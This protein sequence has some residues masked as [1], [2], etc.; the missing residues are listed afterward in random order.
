M[1]TG[2]LTELNL[3]INHKSM[4]ISLHIPVNPVVKKIFEKDF[5]NP[6]RLS[7]KQ[8]IGRTLLGIL[9]ISKS[10]YNKYP[11]KQTI[12]IILSIYYFNQYGIKGIN[13]ENIAHLSKYIEDKF[14]ERLFLFLDS[15]LSLK[16][17]ITR[18]SKEKPIM[19]INDSILEFLKSYNLTEDEIS[20]EAL[21][22]KYYRLRVVH[23]KT[24]Y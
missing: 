22:K 9:A 3:K 24:V 4:D 5:G 15:R 13:E 20:L 14:R 23:E 18:T 8:S 17:K 12:T 16:N 11:G 2:E 1:G 6:Y 10:G 19:K 21:K 7:T